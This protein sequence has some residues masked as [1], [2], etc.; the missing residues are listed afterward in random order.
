MWSEDD[1]IDGRCPDCKG[2]CI[3]VDIGKVI[4]VSRC[5]ELMEKFGKHSNDC[6]HANSRCMKSEWCCI[7][8]YDKAIEKLKEMQK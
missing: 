3:P 8:G 2:S 4:P 5:I 1:L 7:C 6:R